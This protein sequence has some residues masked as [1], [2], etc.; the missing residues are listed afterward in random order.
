MRRACFLAYY[1]GE[2]GNTSA[3]PPIPTVINMGLSLPTT[4]EVSTE[5]SDSARARLRTRRPSL[6]YAESARKQARTTEEVDVFPTPD[7][8]LGDYISTF[9]NND[10]PE[11]PYNV[12]M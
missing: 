10:Q 4:S 5:I 7:D 8:N 3:T 2:N 9:F 12:S 1:S 11:A 6:N